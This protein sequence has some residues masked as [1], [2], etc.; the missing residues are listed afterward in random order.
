MCVGVSL[1]RSQARRDGG[2]H[3]T[4]LCGPKIVAFL[5]PS[6]AARSRQL[7]PGR[8]AGTINACLIVLSCFASPR[9][10]LFGMTLFCL[11]SRYLWI[12]L[13]CVIHSMR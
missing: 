5:R 10:M 9:F 11:T 6:Y 12:I 4:P 8:W 3:P 1:V 2:M 7:N 13:W